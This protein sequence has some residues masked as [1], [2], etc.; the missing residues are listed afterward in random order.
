MM[1]I[2]DYY[3]LPPDQ[4]RAALLRRLTEYKAEIAQRA[5][6]ASAASVLPPADPAGPWAMTED[7]T[8]FLRRLVIRPE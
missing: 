7:D 5:R 6:A 2:D 1:P 4:L 8:Q 3:T